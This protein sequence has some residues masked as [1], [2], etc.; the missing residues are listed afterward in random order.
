ME[1][2]RHRGD[3]TSSVRTDQSIFS[4][5]LSDVSS[6]SPHSIHKHTTTYAPFYEADTTPFILFKFP[7]IIFRWFYTFS[8]FFFMLITSVMIAVTPIDVIAQTSGSSLSGIKVFIVIGICIVFV[9][10]SIVIYL[11]RIFQNRVAMND[12][13][14][15]SAYIPG[16]G[17]LPNRCI[18]VIDERIIKCDEI[19]MR[20]GPLYNKAIIINHAGRAPPEYVQNRNKSANG[21]GTLLPPDSCYEDIIR[22]LGDKFMIDG[23]ILTQIDLPKNLSFKEIL[24]YLMEIYKNESHFKP[25]YG[26]V[27][28]RLIESYEKFK[29]GPD[30][31]EEAEIIEFMLDFDTLVR[32]LQYNYIDNIGYSSKSRRNSKVRSFNDASLLERSLSTRGRSHS[33]IQRR[34]NDQDDHLDIP[35][36]RTNT[37]ELIPSFTID[38]NSDAADSIVSNFPRGS[39]GR[40]GSLVSV[41]QSKLALGRK[42]YREEYDPDLTRDMGY[43]TD[44]EDDED[45]DQHSAEDF[46]NF[47]H[48]RSR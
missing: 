9:I 32:Y 29:F 10:S 26:L 6:N 14:S 42:K 35:I 37:G 23:R 40:S 17:D 27:I 47:R 46:Y 44:S 4:S 45:D 33:F 12:I 20:A 28:K 16:K 24:I 41:V 48:R 13:P 38:S 15:K 34:K 18:K 8:L 22:S 11:S 5:S 39:H 43:V 21:E 1:G 2:I 19:S 25:E 7:R 30:L 36:V 31:I 3:G